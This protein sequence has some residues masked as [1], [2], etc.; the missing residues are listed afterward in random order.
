MGYAIPI[1]TASLIIEKLMNRELVSESQ[2]AYLGVSGVDVSDS[3]SN[4]YHM[5]EGVYV[6]RVVEGSPADIAGITQGDIITEF[7]GSKVS[8]RQELEDQM[9]YYKAGT[10]VA[11]I[12]QRISNENNGEYQEQEITVTLGR[13]N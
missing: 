10:Q 3:V 1:D 6:Y 7:D 2:T 11:I 12:V 13:K 8:S 4:S 5:P 9:Q